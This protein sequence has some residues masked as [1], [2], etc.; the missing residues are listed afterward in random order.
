[1]VGDVKEVVGIGVLPSEETLC[2]ITT[3]EIETELK[4]IAEERIKVKRVL[5]VF[6][7]AMSKV[8]SLGGTVQD[9]VVDS[10]TFKMLRAHGGDVFELHTDYNFLKRGLFGSV[11]GIWVW[12]SSAAKGINC[13]KNN[14]EELKK[15]FPKI[16]K[17]KEEFNR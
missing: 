5:A 6:S 15:M 13:F 7:E 17:V 1:M 16:H 3:D 12:V 2:S 9:I 8:E 10:E 4:S 11:W 14:S